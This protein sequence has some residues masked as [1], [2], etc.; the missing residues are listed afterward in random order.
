MLSSN[1]KAGQSRT[2]LDAW[3]PKGPTH[4]QTHRF[5]TA[6]FQHGTD[7]TGWRLGFFLVGAGSRHASCQQPDALC[8]RAT[9]HMVQTGGA[10]RSPNNYIV[11]LMA[12]SHSGPTWKPPLTGTC[13]ELCCLEEDLGLRIF[14]S[15]RQEPSVSRS[16]LRAAPPISWQLALADEAPELFLFLP[17]QAQR[18]VTQQRDVAMTDQREKPPRRGQDTCRSATIPSSTNV[19]GGSLSMPLSK[20]IPRT[21]D[22]PRHLTLSGFSGPLRSQEAVL[23]RPVP[24][25]PTPKYRS[26]PV[27]F[28]SPPIR[29]QG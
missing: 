4:G 6:A 11:S 16:G 28:P 27:H 5:E 17:P 19:T 15:T 22:S 21:A 24:L 25:P 8:A 20:L 10:K 3:E 23:R 2:N 12:R 29:P 7:G 9:Q 14:N 26:L 18:R 13:S 1:T